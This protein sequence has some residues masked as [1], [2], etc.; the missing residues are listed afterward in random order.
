MRYRL[1]NDCCAVVH[2]GTMLTAAADGSIEAAEEAAPALLAHGVE[3][4]SAP[5][6]PQPAAPPLPCL[7]EI[8]TMSRGALADALTAL[9]HKALSTST[10]DMRRTLRRA[11]VA[12]PA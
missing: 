10:E 1:P 6:S 5:T 3:P 12:R 8:E 11:L 2:E 9:G 4:W 7:G